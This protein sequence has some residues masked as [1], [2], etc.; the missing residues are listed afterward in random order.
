M[1]DLEVNSKSIFIINSRYE[2]YFFKSNSINYY[3]LS[4]LLT[5]NIILVQYFNE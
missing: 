1:N 4:Q 3:K 2:K 5:F